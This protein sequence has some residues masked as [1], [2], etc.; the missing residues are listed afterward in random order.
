M[1]ANK[2]GHIL[3]HAAHEMR[4]QNL[5]P[6]LAYDAQCHCGTLFDLNMECMLCRGQVTVEMRS[7]REGLSFAR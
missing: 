5:L 1:S 7:R 2:G 4:H 3:D 6:V